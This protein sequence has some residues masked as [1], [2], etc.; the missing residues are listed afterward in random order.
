M[1]TDE[2]HNKYL[3]TGCAS[4]YVKVWT[5]KSL[6]RAATTRI[7]RRF[8]VFGDKKNNHSEIHRQWA[9]SAVANTSHEKVNVGESRSDELRM[10]DLGSSIGIDDSEH[11]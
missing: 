10:R 9:H 6:E 11:F 1:S 5:L 8:S 2:P 7:H 4:G 3:F